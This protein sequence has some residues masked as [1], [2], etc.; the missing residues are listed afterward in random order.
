MDTIGHVLASQ[1][2]PLVTTHLEEMYGTKISRSG[3]VPIVAIMT[4]SGFNQD[5]S[6]LLNKS[7]VER[8]LFTSF[9]YHSYK[10]EEKNAGADIEKFENPTKFEGVTGLKEADYS[11]IGDDG[12]P[13]IG[14]TFYNGDILIGKS[15]SMSNLQADPTENEVRRDQKRDRSFVLRTDEA[16]VVDAVFISKNLDGNKYVKV[17][18]RST[19]IPTVGD[20]FS[21]RHGQK[22]VCGIMI[23]AVDFPSTRDGIVPDLIIN[24]H[25]IP[26]RM[27]IGMV[28]EMLLSKVAC[29]DCECKFGT[30]FTGMSLEEIASQLE[31][32]GLQ[33]Y[34]NEQLF[35]GI[36]GEALESMIFIAPCY[37]QRLKHMVVDKVHA[38]NRGSC[39]IL[40]RAPAEGRSK[41]GGLRI[42]EME[43]DSI[44]SHGASEV[45]RDRLFH[46]SDVFETLV[47]KQ[48]GSFS[49]EGVDSAA[50][51]W[52]GKLCINCN[53]GEH[54]KM[55]QLPYSMK[56]LIQEL[57]GAHIASSF[58]F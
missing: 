50:E 52:G 51:Q 13:I 18:V 38:R 3:S 34:G 33:K 58:K 29:I 37:Y 48:C 41:D 47:C 45:A 30:P 31:A 24:P 27:T 28:L 10:D 43:K 5:D 19:R 23:D 7:S 22:G 55:I 1:Q 21:A 46:Q 9:S 26:S 20:K 8:G 32:A 36:T 4:Y 57:A 42:G 53:T 40:T 44:I 35:N 49:R 15:V 56:L 2:R 25:A 12:L 17:R 14:N 11:K 39:Q 54:C 6:I 16:V